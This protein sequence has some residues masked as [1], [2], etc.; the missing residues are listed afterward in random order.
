VEII[1]YLNFSLFLLVLGVLPNGPL[2]ADARDADFPVPISVEGIQVKSTMVLQAAYDGNP[3][4]FSAIKGTASEEGFIKQQAGFLTGGDYSDYSGTVYPSANTS[5]PQQ[6]FNLFSV[7]YKQIQPDTLSARFLWGNLDYALLKSANFPTA[8]V[9]LLVVPAGGSFDTDFGLI[10]DPVVQNLSALG[11]AAQAHPGLYGADRNASG[12]YSVDFASPFP[13]GHS[14]NNKITFFFSGQGVDCGLSKLGRH[15]WRRNDRFAGK[16]QRLIDFF[17]DSNMKL[18]N[19]DVAGYISDFSPK[20]QARLQSMFNGM[21]ADQLQRYIV[22]FSS[23]AP[24]IK[25]I[26]DAGQVKFIF[27]RTVQGGSLTY[28]TVT[29][30]AGQF[31]RVN[32]N[33]QGSID[34]LLTSGPFM[35]TLSDLA[36][37]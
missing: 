27:Y 22:G 36:K 34:A 16:Y 37:Y 15:S 14:G 35:T 3:T 32:A 33:F 30:N 4:S 7:A 17:Q 28:G 1:K 20:S 5:D 6:Q 9:P 13:S 19:G 12:E 18:I 25:F 24:Q 11:R 21:T 8:F 10:L 31:Q 23:A 26:L 29:E 2:F